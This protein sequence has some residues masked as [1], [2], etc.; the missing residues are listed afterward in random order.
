MSEQKANLISIQENLLLIITAVAERKKIRMKRKKRGSKS[1][2]RDRE[3]SSAVCVCETREK[4]ASVDVTSRPIRRFLL[5]DFEFLSK[6]M[7]E[8]EDEPEKKRGKTEA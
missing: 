8:S 5:R 2:T 7:P 1:E 3:K 6:R 4:A